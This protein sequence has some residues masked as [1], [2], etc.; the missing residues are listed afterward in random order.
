MTVLKK[1]WYQTNDNGVRLSDTAAD[2]DV[3]EL[4][5]LIVINAHTPAEVISA[6]A[7]NYVYLISPDVPTGVIINDGSRQNTIRFHA[8]I[9]ITSILMA[10]D[11]DNPVLF[12]TLSNSAVLE[13]RTLDHD[14]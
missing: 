5:N 10:T 7:G 4:S 3:F 11:S 8:G 13:I 2:A 6:G 12:I 14:I 9:D 1:G